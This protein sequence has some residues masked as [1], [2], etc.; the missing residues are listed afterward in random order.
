MQANKN[1]LS[2]ASIKASKPTMCSGLSIQLK[3]PGIINRKNSSRRLFQENPKV[4]PQ[5]I[6]LMVYLSME[7]LAQFG[8]ADEPLFNSRWT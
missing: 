1:P 4:L 6:H 7:D 2:D 8:L 5:T 3:K